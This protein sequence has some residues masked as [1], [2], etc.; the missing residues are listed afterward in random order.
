MKLSLN[1]FFGWWL[2][3]QCWT[4]KRQTLSTPLIFTNFN[5]TVA[6]GENV[7]IFCRS[8]D[9]F[10]GTFYLTRFTSFLKA[11]TVETKDTAS[12]QAEFS[13]PLFSKSQ[14]GMYNCRTCLKKGPCSSFSDSIYLN[15]T[16]PSL[17]KPSIKILN[18]EEYPYFHIWCAGM[19]PGLTFALIDS[20]QQILYKVADPGRKGVEFIINLAKLK[21][22]ETYTCQ[23]HFERSPFVWSLPSELL[24][25][26]LR[27]PEMMNPAIE[28]IPG[29]SSGSDI[30]NLYVWVRLAVILL[31]LISSLVATVWFKRRKKSHGSGA[32]T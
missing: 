32:P 2:A 24:V 27:D 23:Y 17:S 4:T 14:G 16:D 13:F 9:N 5:G 3:Q 6:L 25:L 15:L 22:L 8:Q 29:G 20:R 18:V 12:N 28:T 26:H 31:L 21:A 10:V 1:I 19:Q 11:E 30:I 7:T